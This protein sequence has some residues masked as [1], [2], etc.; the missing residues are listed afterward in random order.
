MSDETKDPKAEAI[1]AKSVLT[2]GDRL[3]A[4]QQRARMEEVYRILQEL[5]TSGQGQEYEIW[6]EGFA[7]TG[8]SGTACHHGWG[9]G[10]TFHEACELFFANSS[11]Y[12]PTDNT[13]WSC[14]LFSNE[15]DARKVFG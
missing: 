9:Y 7:T 13:F 5:R 3:G 6:S 15:A 1:W 2:V 14:R 11:I 10:R 12:N 8:D 4:A